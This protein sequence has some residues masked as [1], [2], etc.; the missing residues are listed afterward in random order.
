MDSSDTP[1]HNPPKPQQRE[2]Q[3]PKFLTGS[4]LNHI[5]VMTGTGAVGLMAIFV[6]DLANLIFL[7]WL[8]DEAVVA[9]VGYGSSILFLTI[10]IGIGLS[11]AAI[12]LVA[13]AVGA[14]DDV[15]A[16]RFTVNSLL[17]T[18]IVA[19]GL[20]LI[21]WLT[22]PLALH[23]LGAKGRTFDLASSY[24]H[25]LVPSLAPLALGMTAGGVLRS[26]GDARRA[27]NVTL[28]GAIVNVILDPVFIFGFGWGL[29]GAACASVIARFAIMAVGLY[30]VVHVHN[31]M[32]RPQWRLFLADV[33]PMSVVAIPAI[34]ANIATPFSNAYVT[35]AISGYGDSAVAGWTIIGRVLPVAFGA[36]YAL[37][38]SIG[39]ILGQNYGAGKFDRM[40]QAFKLA[41]QVTAAFTVTAWIFLALFAHPLAAIMHA[42]GE[43]E[44]LIVFYCRWLTPLFVFMGALFIS[45]AA[46]NT[47][48]RP[49]TSMLLNWGRATIGTVPF[50][51]AGGAVAGAEGALAGH[52]LGGIAFGAIAVWLCHRHMDH[53]EAGK[54]PLQT[55]AVP[56][57]LAAK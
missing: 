50:V 47:L 44:R 25:I 49:R 12:S 48:G 40:R 29:E 27:M 21:V 30:G 9:A 14:H 20:S 38:G 53:L 23:T 31:L 32:G 51:L 52:M 24:L 2:R 7:S 13:P 11:I 16:R 41:L 22:I 36:I 35:N 28:I 10:S 43:A 17:A 37:S 46:F 3:A 33:R 57:E 19:A 55:A 45:N 54:R 5:L 15:K 4:L 6:G 56:Q 39:P 34:L 26:V 18:L 42:T 1:T 8:K